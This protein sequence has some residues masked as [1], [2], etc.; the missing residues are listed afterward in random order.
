MQL[1][2]RKRNN[3]TVILKNMKLF[4]FSSAMSDINK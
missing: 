1:V 3:G 2:I 4:A